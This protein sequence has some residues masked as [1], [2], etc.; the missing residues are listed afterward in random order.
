MYSQHIDRLCGCSTFT[1]FHLLCPAFGAAIYINSLLLLLFSL[2]SSSPPFPRGSLCLY[3]YGK[4][5]DSEIPNNLRDL[6][7]KTTLPLNMLPKYVVGWGFNEAFREDYQNWLDG[8]IKENGLKVG[9]LI[10]QYS[11][12]GKKNVI[13]SV[14]PI[15]SNLLGYIIFDHEQGTIEFTNFHANPTRENFAVGGTTKDGT[16][17]QA[18]QFREWM[19]LCGLALVKLG[20]YRS[21]FTD[22]AKSTI[23]LDYRGELLVS[24]NPLT[25]SAKEKAKAKPRSPGDLEANHLK[26]VSLIVGGEKKLRAF[27]KVK[28]EAKGKKDAPDKFLRA[29]KKLT[30]VV[31]PPENIIR[32][33][34]GDLVLDPQYV[35]SIYLKGLR[36]V[37]VEK[38]RWGP[39]QLYCYNFPDSHTDPDRGMTITT[40]RLAHK[41]YKIWEHIIMESQNPRS[42]EL[43]E[44][45]SENFV[46]HLN[47]NLEVFTIKLIGSIK[48]EFFGK[49]WEYIRD[50]NHE[51]FYYNESSDDIEGIFIIENSLRRVPRPLKDDVWKILRTI[52]GGPRTPHEEQRHLFEA[53]AP[54]NELEL[55]SDYVQN[56][57]WDLRSCLALNTNTDSMRL[58][59]V[60]G[61]NLSFNPAYIKATSE[62]RIHNIWTSKND[63][64]KIRYCPDYYIDGED[65]SLCHHTVRELWEQMAPQL[66]RT[67]KNDGAQV[68]EEAT[69]NSMRN[70]EYLR[71]KTF[72]L[73]DGTPRGVRCSQTE[74]GKEVAVSWELTGKREQRLRVVLH[75]TECLELAKTRNELRILHLNPGEDNRCECPSKTAEMG[76]QG[77]IFEDLDIKV[78]YVPSVS[79]DHEDAFI[80]LPPPA[81]QPKDAVVPEPGIV[82]LEDDAPELKAGS[83]LDNAIAIEPESDNEPD[84]MALDANLDAVARPR[85]PAGLAGLPA[86][87]RIA[88]P[89][90]PERGHA[91]QIGVFARSRMG[92]TGPPL[93]DAVSF[94]KGELSSFGK[95]F[96]GDSPCSYRVWVTREDDDHYL[97]NRKQD[98]RQQPEGRPTKRR[99]EN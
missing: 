84:A 33:P 56:L 94:T 34:Y 58:I 20:Y 11:Q 51:V 76:A 66:K 27:N 14:H 73:I 86:E 90:T 79:R 40:T 3:C 77:V 31:V 96:D 72:S 2:P 21:T 87:N 91:D 65:H 23:R 57:L 89:E 36:R 16:T 26:N 45:Y 15:S 99:R 80:A 48:P 44:I 70:Y 35:G 82:K 81:V 63:T 30:L 46:N 25:D 12:E 29:L 24:L 83:M 97:V 39:T 53:A 74:K 78:N 38:K 75:S 98:D 88:D 69:E 13:R 64:H 32:T 28:E 95:L 37:W 93:T 85:T 9:V 4:Q 68:Q 59:F 7:K 5:K 50:T 54:I 22:G 19:K 55:E 60:D 67:Q 61:G 62:W 8:Q 92:D 18:G 49:I 6:T 71:D 47:E 1:S 41:I 52:P 17:K 42:R 43:V 10:P